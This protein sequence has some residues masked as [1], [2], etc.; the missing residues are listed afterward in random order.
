M[1][2]LSLIL[3]LLLCSMQLH[4][5]MKDISGKISDENN[6][7]LKDVKITVEDLNITA[8]S[9]ENGMY[10]L[11]I[12]DDGKLYKIIFTYPDLVSK[13]VYVTSASMDLIETTDNINVML[14]SDLTMM[15]LEEL[16]NITVIS[17]SKIE[18]KQS[19]APNIIGTMNKETIEAYGFESLNDVL[20]SQPGFAPAQDYDRRT[21]GFRGLFEGWNNNHLL[22]LIDGVPF[23]DN[24][25]GTSYTWEITPLIFTKSLEIIRGP[26]GALYGSNAMNGVITINTIEAS[27]FNNIGEASVRI[28]SENTQIYDFSIGNQ[29]KKFGYISAFNTYR[30]DGLDYNSYDGTGERFDVR[31]KR[32]SHYFFTKIYGL[33]KFEGLSFQYHEQHWQ[34]ETGHGWLFEIPDLGE[35]LKEYRRVLSLRYAPRN[36]SHAFNYE[37]TTKYQI[38]GIDWNLRYYR[39]GAFDGFYPS[40]VTEYLQTDAED[41]FLRFQF[42]YNANKHILLG[43]V[44]TNIFIYDGDHAHYTNTDLT[45]AGGFTMTDGTV[46]PAGEGWFAPYPNGENRALGPWFEFALNKPVKNMAVFAQYIS[47]KFADKLQ[48]TLSG[49]FDRQWFDYVK[50]YDAGK[51]ED[52]KSFQLFTPRASLVFS[53]TDKLTFKLIGG[54]AFRTPAPTEMFGSNTWTLASNIEQ[55]EPEKVTNFDLA[56]EFAVNKNIVV[57]LNGFMF[58]FENIIAYS[59]ENNNL[60]TN[61]Y[62]ISNSG[63]ETELQYTSSKLSGFLNLT[64]SMRTDEEIKDANITENTS[65]VTWAPPITFNFGTSYA[66]EKI[67]A[68]ILAHYQGEVQRRAN[69]NTG[70][71]TRPAAVDPWLNIDLKLSY[72]LNDM[73][74]ISVLGKNLA[75][76]EQYLIK[77]FAYPFDYMR[78]GRRVF[79][80]FDV[81]F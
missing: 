27:K 68:S 58:N 67:S 52:D 64:Y 15:S 7:A 28:G 39:N 63:V 29:G 74:T 33:K 75:D 19:E 24:L 70:I 42:D 5:Q 53:A 60:S 35:S 6:R 4:S 9:D 2:N 71:T 30:T 26:G 73:A 77:N 14:K 31:D 48:L 17:A 41:I 10:T 57:K 18:Q 81:K 37:L 78:Y 76:Q 49:R 1:K 51:P 80:Q 44:E 59:V 46:I 34:Y 20:Y 72:H 25:Y 43:G 32:Q 12:P 13:E 62:T 69:E 11:S 8:T 38:H 40:G 56:A 45:D 23:N 55:L 66:H 47:P 65:E 3:F 22:T 54:Q 50:I 61:L 21:V 16:L 79:L 36:A